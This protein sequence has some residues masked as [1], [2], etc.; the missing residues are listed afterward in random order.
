[1]LEVQE[2]A[3]VLLRRSAA[4]VAARRQLEAL[5]SGV[6][7]YGYREDCVLPVQGLNVVEADAISAALEVDHASSDGDGDGDGDRDGVVTVPVHAPPVVARRLL[8]SWEAT[9]AVD[10]LALSVGDTSSLP[11]RVEEGPLRR[12]VRSPGVLAD[13]VRRWVLDQF[14]E[15]SAVGLKPH[16]VPA[17]VR[18]EGDPAVMSGVLAEQRADL[19]CV[20]VQLL[21]VGESGGRWG[22]RRAAMGM[23][24]ILR[25]SVR[26]WCVAT[27]GA[28]PADP[29]EAKQLVEAGRRLVDD[30]LIDY[31]VRRRKLG[32][33]TVVEPAVIRGLSQEARRVKGAEA[34]AAEWVRSRLSPAG[35]QVGWAR[36]W[37]SRGR[38]REFARLLSAGDEAA[39]VRFGLA[40]LS[41]ADEAP[42]PAVGSP[43]RRRSDRASRPSGRAPS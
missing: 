4:D 35:S 40:W 9:C 11:G 8:E 15:L 33:L 20:M 24:G 42:M 14:G 22:S 26:A 25:D 39:L 37:G 32:S 2:Q 29:G 43:T 5:A 21:L 41:R 30:G 27:V 28:G 36:D 31:A 23:L 13:P 3:N 12:T 19:A 16:H 18:L 38:L 10:W 17:M 6:V 1:L 7:G 34:V